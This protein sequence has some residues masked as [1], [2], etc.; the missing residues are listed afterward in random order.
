LLKKLQLRYARGFYTN[1]TGYNQFG[2]NL[3]LND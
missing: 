3:R 2:L 1:T